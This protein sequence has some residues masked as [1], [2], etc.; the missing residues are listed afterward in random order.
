MKQPK[1]PAIDL[2]FFTW[3]DF[4]TYV[5]RTSE[6]RLWDWIC[7]LAWVGSLFSLFFGV[8]LFLWVGSRAGVVYPGYVWFIPV[9]ALVFST[10][11]AIDTIGHRTIYKVELLRA[12]AHVH[13]MI[14]ATA[15]PSV[16]ALSFGFEYPD[17][18]RMPIIGL[19]ALSFFYSII[20]ESMHW[21]RYLKSGTDR[22]EAWSHF[23]AILGHVFLI[24]AWWHWYDTG[25]QGFGQTL[26]ALKGLF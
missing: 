22:V 20:D 4:R 5:G 18:M 26:E 12:E 24:A 10:A 11:L 23:F 14:V 1:T 19:I 2:P 3:L 9:G 17:L 15:I 8:S 25:Y 21:V 7:Y 13:H 16:V 6:F